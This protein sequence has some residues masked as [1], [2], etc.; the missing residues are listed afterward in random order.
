MLIVMRADLVRVM[1]EAEFVKAF[2]GLE[3]MTV[4]DTDANE[5]VQMANHVLAIGTYPETAGS[6]TNFKGRVQRLAQAFP[7]PG[8]ALTGI[9]AI[10]RLGHAIDGNPRE[11]DAAAIFNSIATSEAPFEG[12]SFD[13][14]MPHGLALKDAT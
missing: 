5:T 13:A 10:A 11:A 2:G 6:F 4:I 3:Y 9:E 7:P 8:D 14:L 1:G 12:M